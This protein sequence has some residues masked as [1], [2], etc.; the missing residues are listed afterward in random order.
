MPWSINYIKISSKRAA[1]AN[2]V[3]ARKHRYYASRFR[4]EDLLKKLYGKNREE[5]QQNLVSIEWVDGSKILF[6]SKQN[7]AKQLKKVII[8]LKELPEKYDKF[9]SLIART[10]N[11]R[12]IWRGRWYHYD[13]MHFEYRPELFGTID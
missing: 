4:N 12:F 3:Y 8:K 13:T 9:L 11:Y 2:F 6:N 10:L 7:A 5:I 1:W